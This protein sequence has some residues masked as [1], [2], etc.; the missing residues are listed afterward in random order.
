MAHMIPLHFLNSTTA[1]AATLGVLVFAGPDLVADGVE[2]GF[3]EGVLFIC[4]SG[5]MTAS[6]TCIKPLCVLYTESTHFLLAR[7]MHNQ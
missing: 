1:A 3:A 7:S 6:N 4:S 2:V 5:T